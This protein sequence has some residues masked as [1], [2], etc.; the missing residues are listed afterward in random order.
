MGWIKSIKTVQSLKSKITFN[1]K[2]YSGSNDWCSYETGY[3]EVS[4][5]LFREETESQCRFLLLITQESSWASSLLV[6]LVQFEIIFLQI[7]L[8]KL[9]LLL[10]LAT[11][12]ILEPQDKKT[13][14]LLS[15]F[16]IEFASFSYHFRAHYNLRL[17]HLYNLALSSACSAIVTWFCSIYL[18]SPFSVSS[19]DVWFVVSSDFVMIYFT[20]QL[21]LA[22]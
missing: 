20:T 13:L 16:F 5:W 14:L 15:S 9:H 18:Y 12:V 22:I 4:S 21:S 7:W 6:L 17:G 3:S 1:I 8:P 11:F 19:C 10:Y 2:T